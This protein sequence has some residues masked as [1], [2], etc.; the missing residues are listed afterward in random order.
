MSKSNPQPDKKEHM[1]KIEEE[2]LPKPVRKAR[3]AA[4]ER[5][6]QPQVPEESEPS[7]GSQAK[8]KGKGKGRGHGKVKMSPNV[9]TAVVKSP[10]VKKERKRRQRRA[11]LLQTEETLEDKIMQGLFSQHMKP[12]DCLTYQDLQS[13][14]TTNGGLAGYKR[15]SLSVYW[16]RKACGVKFKDDPAGPQIAYFAY[17]HPKIQSYNHL[18]CVAYV[19]AG[20]LVS[21]LNCS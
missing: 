10:A 3:K 13:H 7:A 9:K 4:A 17:K 16:G 5:S 19:S 11:P 21:L 2:M 18:M 14:L 12:V 15:C 1:K 8:A 20:L 6:A